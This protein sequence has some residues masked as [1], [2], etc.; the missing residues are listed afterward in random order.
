M[1]RNLHF[2]KGK[3]D[4]LVPSPDLNSGLLQ[5]LE[6]QVA[7]IKLDL[8]DV[9][10]DI[11]SSEKEEEDLLQL[12]DGLREALFEL[13]LQIRRLLQDR[14]SNPSTLKSES[15]VRLLKID[16][17][18]FD[19]NIINWNML[20][21]QFDM[22]INSQTQLTNVEKLAYLRHALKDRPAIQTIQ[23]LSRLADQYEEVV[24]LKSRYDRPCLVH[25][26]QI[27]AILEA[28]SVKGV[29]GEDLRHLHDVSS[30]PLRALATT[31]QNITESFITSMLE[32]KLDQGK[33][34][35]WQR[36]SQEP[37]DVPYYSA[38]LEFHNLKAQAFENA[39]CESDH[40][41]RTSAAKKEC[42]PQTQSYKVN[43]DDRCVVCKLGRHPLYACKKFRSLPHEQ[44]LTFLKQNGCCLNCL[45]PG[46]L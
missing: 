20:W 25:R 41:H 5:Q 21:E 44:M 16:V 10:R 19:R 24:R 3:I 26:E 35:E 30:Q 14:P 33:M 11:L 37:K 17:P 32:M 22:S 36:H 8:S 39:V 9:I 46:H 43:V 31:K 40:K 18:T 23:Q 2:G 12:K 42:Y 29:N 4:P 27:R 1:E 13:S 28:P 34:F 6:E 45:K 15:R 38:L 7:S